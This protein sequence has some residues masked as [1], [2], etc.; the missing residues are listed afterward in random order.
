MSNVD[1]KQWKVKPGDKVDLSKC[2]TNEDDGME[3]GDARELQGKLIEKFRELQALMYAEGKRSL[4]VVIQAMD[5]IGKDSTVRHVFGPLNPA[6]VRDKP[7]KAPSEFELA[8]D[9]LWRIHQNVPRKG[10][11]GIFNRSHY[12]DV[13]TVGVKNLAPKKRV[14]KRFDHCINFEKMLVDEGAAV[15]KI[16]LHGSK[17]YQ[18]ERLQRRLDRPDKH[19]KFNLADL[20]ERARWDQYQVAYADC[21]TRTSTDYAPWF[22]IPAEKRWYRDVV[23]TQL[24]VDTLEGLDMEYPEA[25]F[26]ASKIVIED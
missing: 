22:V 23:L 24:M 18:K 7:F 6:G 26:D 15:V 1:W 19:W 4:L 12:E 3:K 21:F 11:I 8:H 16:F 17:G 13:V 9:F 25:H 10:M 20:E 2:P 5:A 14:E